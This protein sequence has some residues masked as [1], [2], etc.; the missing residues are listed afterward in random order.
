[1]R[2]AAR[3]LHLPGAALSLLTLRVNFPLTL[4]G[5]ITLTASLASPSAIL[6]A[7][8]FVFN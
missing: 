3:P 8:R 6:T 2:R 7:Q 1:M 5:Q 4:M